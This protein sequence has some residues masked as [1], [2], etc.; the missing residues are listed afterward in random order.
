LVR[1]K[2]CFSQTR[3]I[4]YGLCFLAGWM[5]NQSQ[6]TY[7][8]NQI[9]KILWRWSWR[10]VKIKIDIKAKVLSK[11]FQHWWKISKIDDRVCHGKLR[12]QH[13]FRRYDED[14][15]RTKLITLG[16]K[17]KTSLKSSRDWSLS[18]Q[19]GADL[20]QVKEDD[21]NIIVN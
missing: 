1:G 21:C 10:N 7:E 4:S 11:K 17:K 2:F 15:F 13:I 6:G 20:F 5:W 12:G 16:S 3:W 19:N 18:N 8:E 14:E 9:L